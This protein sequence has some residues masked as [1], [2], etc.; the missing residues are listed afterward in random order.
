MLQGTIGRLF[1]LDSSLS[2]LY[3]LNV[4]YEGGRYGI[5]LTE[6]ELRDALKLPQDQEIDQQL[7]NEYVGKQVQLSVNVS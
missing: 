4:V 3:K 6:S 7:L 5:E 2:S 1:P